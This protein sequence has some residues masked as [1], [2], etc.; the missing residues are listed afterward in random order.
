MARINAFLQENITGMSVVQLFRRE[1]RNREAFAAINRSHTD[2]NMAQIFYYAVFYP[3]IELLAAVATAL[4][5]LY[6]GW[7]VLAGDAHPGRAR[8]LHPVLRALLAA[9]LRPLREV[10]H[11]AGGDGLLGADL[12]PA[13]HGAE[14]RRRPQT[15]VRLDAGARAA[16][17]SRT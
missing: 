7:R 13:R 9:D 6:G 1:E 3:A 15:P 17:A 4:I 8:G 11:P 12:R 10:Q 14:G 16:S 5:L 2:A